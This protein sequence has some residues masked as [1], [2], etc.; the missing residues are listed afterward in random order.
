MRSSN[1]GSSR[2]LSPPR[3]ARTVLPLTALGAG[4]ACFAYA[5]VYEVRSFRLRRF[6]VPVLP[7]GAAP[8]RVL[9]ISDLH[10]TPRQAKKRAWVRDLTRLEPDLVLNTGDNI[11]HRNAVPAAL[12][13]LGPLLDR[14]GAFVFGSNDYYAPTLKNPARYLWQRRSRLGDR[15]KSLPWEDLQKGLV[16]AG[17]LDL[18]NA[19]ETL[20]LA[21]GREVE[22][23]GVDDPHIRRDRYD[24]VAGAARWP[25]P[26]RGV[27]VGRIGARQ[28]IRSAAG[29]G[30]EPGISIGIAHA[31]YRRVLDR[32][33]A[34]GFPLIVVG[35]TH[36][37]QVCVPGFGALVTN[38]DLDRR[39]AKGLSRYGDS[40]LHVSAGLGTSPYAPFRFACPPEATLLTLVPT[41]LADSR[42][43]ARG[44]SFVYSSNVAR[45]R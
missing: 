14:P 12:D 33:T 43:G 9:H 26:N 13:A 2:K 1:I 4:A 25:A 21:D 7:E 6:D 35:H 30:G 29:A 38:S 34:D 15:P 3:Q 5:A 44:G 37:G 23:V 41:D 10:L 45:E 27:G 39:R 16:D 32:M 22:V 31:P 19:R 17:W 40:W 24:Q 11:A 8:T 28:P 18:S 42:Q 36:G 20:R